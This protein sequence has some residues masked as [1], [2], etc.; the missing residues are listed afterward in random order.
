[1]LV[2]LLAA[3]GFLGYEILRRTAALERQ[4]A[5][6]SDRMEQGRTTFANRRKPRSTGWRRPSARSRKRDAPRSAW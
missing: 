1:L 6:L 4:V 3:L 5:G 2:V